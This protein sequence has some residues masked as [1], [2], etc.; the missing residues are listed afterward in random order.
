MKS[1]PTTEFTPENI[2]S[3][4]SRCMPNAEQINWIDITSSLLRFE[5]RGKNF[6]ITIDNLHTEEFNG[7]ILIGS[8]EAALI[9]ALVKKQWLMEKGK[10]RIG[11][12]SGKATPA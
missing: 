7:Q 9:E 6:Q 3:W 10:T 8:D 12:P 11:Q 1:A 4:L 2:V 5:W